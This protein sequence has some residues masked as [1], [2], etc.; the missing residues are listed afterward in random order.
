VLNELKGNPLNYVGNLESPVG[1]Y[2]R[3][4]IFKKETRADTALTRK[5]YD[6]TVVGQSTMEVGAEK[7]RKLK[8]FWSWTR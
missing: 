2:L 6:K 1:V 7:N 3:R 5:R 4:E 8:H